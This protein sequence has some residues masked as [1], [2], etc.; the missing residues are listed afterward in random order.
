LE[1]ARID[2]QREQP[3]LAGERIAALL[4]RSGNDEGIRAKAL[5]FY[6]ANGLFELAENHLRDDAEGGG[7][8]SVVA[9]AG[10]YFSRHREAEARA[11]LAR[12]IRNTDAPATRAAA[13]F[14]IASECKAQNDVPSAMAAVRAAIDLDGDVREY[15]F[16]LGELEAAS[17]RYAGAQSAFERAFALCSTAAQQAE[18][19]QRLYDSLRNQKQPGEDEPRVSLPRPDSAA[20]AT[21]AAA[22]SYLLGLVREAV[23]QPNEARLLRIARWQ[24]WSRNTRLAIDYAS[25]FPGAVAITRPAGVGS[26]A[27]PPRTGRVGC[28]ESPI[29][30]APARPGAASIRPSGR[31]DASFPKAGAGE[32]R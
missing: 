31:G 14:R 7:E 24:Q 9:L 21:S 15:H 25:R 3:H 16:M 8:E 26:T 11:T 6:L 5:A 32:P 27:T 30:L 2:V 20:A 17:G 23:D 13:H 1:R 22:Q 10:F 29:V 28:G 19:D 4:S 18:A 12:L